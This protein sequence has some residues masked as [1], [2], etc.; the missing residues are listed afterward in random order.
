[1]VTALERRRREV[2]PGWRAKAFV[3]AARHAGWIIDA[4]IPRRLD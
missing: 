4:G 2:I 3:W 1:M